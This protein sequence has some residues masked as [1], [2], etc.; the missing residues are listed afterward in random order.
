MPQLV[1]ARRWLS[2]A[3]FVEGTAAAGTARL[4]RI[5]NFAALTMAEV[6]AEVAFVATAAAPELPSRALKKSSLA[7][8]KLGGP[9]TPCERWLLSLSSP[10]L[11]CGE[12]REREAGCDLSTAC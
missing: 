10:P 12:E 11:F 1:S 7:L 8:F 4:R 9:S 3:V 6:L 2:L 5:L